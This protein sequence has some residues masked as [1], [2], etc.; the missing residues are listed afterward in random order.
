MCSSRSK[1]TTMQ[2]KS[3]KTPQMLM[4]ML[5]LV[6]ALFLACSTPGFGPAGGIFTSV[7]VGVY[8]SSTENLTRSGE[9]C[10]MSIL[11]LIAVGDGSVETAA[12]NGGLKTVKVVN[13]QGFSILGLFAQLCT[14]VAGE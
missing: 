11:G 9:A 13:L 14:V 8:G 10:S 1:Q 12:A 3:N 2:T 7:K 5:S 6:S 4:L